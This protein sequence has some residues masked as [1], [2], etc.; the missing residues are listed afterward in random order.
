MNV[1]ELSL[2]KENHAHIFKSGLMTLRLM[3]N[4]IGLQAPEALIAT[5]FRVI[6]IVKGNVDVLRQDFNQCFWSNEFKISPDAQGYS[7]KKHHNKN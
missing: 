6:D 4:G 2:I 7:A 3:G 1:A 5:S